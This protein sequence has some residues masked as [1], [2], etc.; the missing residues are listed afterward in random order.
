MDDLII[1]IKDLKQRR[2]ALITELEENTIQISEYEE[3]IIY[4][5]KVGEDLR[6]IQ[7]T[8]ED[9]LES[10]YNVRRRFTKKGE[11]NILNLFDDSLKGTVDQKIVDITKKQEENNRAYKMSLFCHEYYQAKVKELEIRNQEIANQISAI[12]IELDCLE[13]TNIERGKTKW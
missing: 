10:H 13:S 6:K 3:K 5:E 9:N 12:E 4:Y 11:E 7:K 8:T 1:I 2:E